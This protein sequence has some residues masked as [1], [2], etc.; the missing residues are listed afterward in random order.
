MQVA[1]IEELEE[2]VMNMKK[3]KAPGPDGY[4]VEFYQAEWHFLGK[5]ILKVVE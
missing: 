2:I 1:T 3:G 4:T 5:E